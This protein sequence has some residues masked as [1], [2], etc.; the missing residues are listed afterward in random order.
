VGLSLLGPLPIIH[1]SLGPSHLSKKA[2]LRV[3][4]LFFNAATP[5]IVGGTA[6]TTILHAVTAFIARSPLV[7]DLSIISA[8]ASA[9]VIPWTLAAIMATNKRL[10]ELDGNETLTT[11]EEGEVMGL[12]SK[13]DSRHKVRFVGY[14]IGWAYGLAALLGVVGGW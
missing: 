6:A 8:V 9:S 1:E 7:R 14:G 4:T 12:L 5:Y 13:W 10:L 3:W 11:G 2:K